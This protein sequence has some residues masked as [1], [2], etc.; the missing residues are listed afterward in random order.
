MEQTEDHGL[1]LVC[2]AC[3]NC[4]YRTVGRVMP[5]SSYHAFRPGSET[6]SDYASKPGRRK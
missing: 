3:I 5:D 2:F 1:V 4:G 6:P